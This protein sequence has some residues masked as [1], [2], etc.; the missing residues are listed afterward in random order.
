MQSK[1]TEGDTE[2]YYDGE[3]AVYRSF[4]D[5][6]GSVHWGIFDDGNVRDFL[7]ACSRLNDIIVEK[8]EI[9]GGD[10]VLDLG[11]GNGT[12]AMWLSRS[13]G[14]NVVGIDLRQC[15]ASAPG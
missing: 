9:T 6:E 11:C 8:A 1:F 10:R 4:W 3:D 2:A 12:T 13:Y 14:C 7:K 15:Q 5:G